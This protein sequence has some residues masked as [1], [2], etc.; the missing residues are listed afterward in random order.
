[1]APVGLAEAGSVRHLEAGVGRRAQGDPSVGPD[2]GAGDAQG[3]IAASSGLPAADQ[4]FADADQ[5]IAD[6]DQTSSDDD[7]TIAEADQTSSDD[8][9]NSSDADQTASDTDQTSADEDQ[10]AA[11]DDQAASDRSL[12]HGGDR[13]DHDASRDVRGRSAARRQRTARERADAAN[14]RDVTAAARDL[15][16]AARD[17]AAAAWDR[18]LGKRA[19]GGAQP[20]PALKA[21]L[22]RAMES[23]RSAAADRATAAEGRARA[24]ADR[25][26]AA[27]D[28]AQA[29]RDRAQAAQDRV[30]LAHQLAVAET[31]EL[32]GARARAAG[33]AELEH[34]V[35]RA[36]RTTDELVV[37]YIDVVGLKSVNDADGHAAGDELLRRAVHAIRSHVRT[38]DM[39]VRLGGDEFLCVLSQ[40]SVL[41]A[42]E[43]FEAIK[44]ELANEPG[45]PQIRVGIAALRPEDTAGELVKRADDELPAG[46]RR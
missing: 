6:A 28:R 36:H 33:L 18:E 12:L 15:A 1:M 41:T 10:A 16:A 39:I 34:E 42:A 19:A 9:Q 7:Q 4:T 46:S 23:R 43:R 14:E 20:E 31:D 25:K 29:A 45:A 30:E 37:G 44:V 26:Q 3:I 38:Y 5:T 2:S 24:A 40:M 11:N 27:R 8:D 22:L 35:D 17:E 13:A 32:T 21:L